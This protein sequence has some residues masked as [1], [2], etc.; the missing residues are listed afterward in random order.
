VVERTDGATAVTKPRLDRSAFTLEF[1]DEFNGDALDEQAWLPHYLPHW[2]TREASRA[3][4]RIAD[5]LLHLR[6]DADQPAWAPGHTGG[7]RVSNLQTG[8]FSGPLGSPVGQHHFAPGLTVSEEQPEARLYLPRRALVEARVAVPSDS[9]SM[10]AL[11]M[12]GYEDSPERS[13]EICIFEIFGSEIVTTNGRTSSVVGHGVHPFGDPDIIDEFHRPAL[14]F[15]AREFHTYSVDWA[16][17]GVHFWVDD[18]HV[19]STSQSPDYPMQ[20]MLNIYEF[21]GSDRFDG[22]D[23]V[24]DTDSFESTDKFDSTDGLDS[25]D[26]FEG[27]NDPEWPGDAAGLYP[28]EMLVDWVRGWRRQ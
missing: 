10:A 12:I 1:S 9:R 15:D 27:G 18:E 28:K 6:I 23:D 14:P 22:S 17:D 13:A 8:A 2:S 3:R 20:L 21:D 7:L 26:S 24:E 4:Y 11:W 16:P 19:T 5:G 25:T